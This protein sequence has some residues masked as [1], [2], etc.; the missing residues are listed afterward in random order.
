M[1]WTKCPPFPVSFFVFS[2][3]L[4][5]SV[6]LFIRLLRHHLALPQGADKAIG[7]VQGDMPIYNLNKNH[8]NE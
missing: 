3:L 2:F 1:G 4:A 7:S 8:A 5:A 6:L